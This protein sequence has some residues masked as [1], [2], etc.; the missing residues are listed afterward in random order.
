MHYFA[1]L[2][3]NFVC[4]E[5]ICVEDDVYE[6]NVSN[7]FVYEN[8]KCI[9]IQSNDTSL[10][11]KKKYI[12]NEWVDSTPHESMLPEDGQLVHYN[13]QDDMWLKDAIGV[14]SALSTTNKTSLVSA[15][16]EV[17]Q[18]VSDGKD[19]IA[20]AITD[21]DSS[22]TIPDNPTFSQLA[23]LIGQIS[24]MK[25]ATGHMQAYTSSNT[26]ISGTT[27]FRPRIVAFYNNQSGSTNFNAGVY[28]DSDYLGL[29]KDSSDVQDFPDI[30]FNAWGVSGGGHAENVFTISNTGFSAVVTGLCTN[31]GWIA[32]G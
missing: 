19:A 7:G 5:I 14:L 9:S 31:I 11:Y 29:T 1:A 12:N 28:V 27:T 20:G 30:N 8:D 15:I 16:N 21:T 24:T 4:T 17:F 3:D 10:V 13:G 26:T 6:M 23:S 25:V 32:I 18:S 22:I 2:N